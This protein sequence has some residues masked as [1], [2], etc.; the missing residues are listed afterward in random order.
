MKKLF[1]FFAL[2]SLIACTAPKTDVL[3]VGTIQRD[4][5]LGVPCRVYLP[6]EYDARRKAQTTY[7]VL[8]LQHGMF[9]SEN[10][11]TDQG[12]LLEHM[13]S[14]L[15]SG[16]AREMVVIMPDNFLG[17]IPPAE[18]QQLMDAPDLTPDGQPIDTENGSAHWRKL[19][20]EQERAYEMSG[21][22]E[23]HFAEFMAAAES[24]YRISNRPDQRAI[25]GLSMGGFHTMHVSHFLHG[26]F[27][28]IGMFSALAASP[29]EGA[30]YSNWEGEVPQA[31]NAA[32]VYWLG[33][34]R[35]DFL[36]DQLQDYRRWLEA[37]QLEYTYYES[38]GGHTWDNWQ[39]YI[40]RFIRLL[41]F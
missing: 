11:W 15:R 34:G 14:L 8:Y 35:D 9:G 17:S 20:Y 21:Y 37:H 22:W 36:Y 16:Q 3:R 32:R 26:Q 38:T 29:T 7:P 28:Y 13:D 33:M 18:R 1:L 6:A 40:C 23:T 27:A 41:Q 4:T 2:F 24:R 31:V 5:I 19:T 30:P 25:A 12:N 39:D 10:D